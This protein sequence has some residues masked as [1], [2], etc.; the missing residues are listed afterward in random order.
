MENNRKYGEIEDIPRANGEDG[1]DFPAPPP[2]LIGGADVMRLLG[3]LPKTQREKLT[4]GYDIKTLA[5]IFEDAEAM[6]TVDAF[7]ENDLSVCRTARAMYMHRNT[8]IYRLNAIRRQT[9]FDL[10]VFKMAVTFKIL[11][12]LYVLR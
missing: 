12:Y 6:R 4:S 2:A 10:R 5:K 7:I 8:L 9:G 11:H 3:T 1:E